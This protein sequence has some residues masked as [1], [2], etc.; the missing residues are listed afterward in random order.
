VFWKYHSGRRQD[1]VPNR[2]WESVVDKD[3]STFR[4]FENVVCVLEEEAEHGHLD[5]AIVFMCTN[6]TTTVKAGLVKGNSSS[7]KLFE[8]LFELVLQSENS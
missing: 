6:S 2:T 7:H 5:N 8:L 3:S 1:K 4:E